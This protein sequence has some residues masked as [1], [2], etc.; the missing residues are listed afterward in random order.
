MEIQNIC[1]LSPRAGSD[2][3]EGEYSS[4]QCSVLSQ[5]NLINIQDSHSQYTQIDPQLFRSFLTIDWWIIKGRK[6]G[7]WRAVRVLLSYLRFGA[8]E[9]V[10]ES[11]LVM[12]PEGGGGG[13]HSRKD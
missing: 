5:Y 12:S 1:P 11:R 6:T 3:R 7:Q 9:D 2:R 13:G 8:G 10:R 4:T